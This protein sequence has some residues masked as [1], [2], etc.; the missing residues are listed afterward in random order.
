MRRT[1]G[2]IV[3]WRRAEAVCVADFLVLVDLEDDFAAAFF[4]AV[5]FAPPEGFF[6]AGVSVLCFS[7]AGAEAAGASCARTAGI[8]DE[9]LTET[10]SPAPA[11]THH[12]LRPNRNTF[13]NLSRGD[14][15]ARTWNRG[16]SPFNLGCLMRYLAPL[17]QKRPAIPPYYFLKFG[18]MT[19]RSS[20]ARLRTTSF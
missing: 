3:R 11:R 7:G 13:F 20:S 9:R 14:A 6:F 15:N 4:F 17:V 18:P 10:Q 5:A 16:Q 19:V 1:R 12:H 8:V 2:E